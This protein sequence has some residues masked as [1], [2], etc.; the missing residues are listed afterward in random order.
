MPRGNRNGNV[1]RP[2]PATRPIGTINGLPRKSK[3]G[4][5]RVMQRPAPGPRNPNANHALWPGV[6]FRRPTVPGWPSISGVRVW[7][8]A[9]TAAVSAEI[10]TTARME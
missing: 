10:A 9:L 4:P 5:G 3:H 6:A 1:A 8:W 7:T 2:L